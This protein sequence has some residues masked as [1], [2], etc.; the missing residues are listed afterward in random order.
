M[1]DFQKELL[2]LHN[3]VKDGDDYKLQNNYYKY[4]DRIL[5]IIPFENRDD[6][7]CCVCSHFNSMGA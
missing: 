1:E 6:H 2:S 3:I 7:N 5:P 4:G